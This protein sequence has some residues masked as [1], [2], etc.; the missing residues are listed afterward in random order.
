MR[1]VRRV[2]RSAFDLE[3]GRDGAPRVDARPRTSTRTS[4]ATSLSS[5]RRDRRMPWSRLGAMWS[6]AR[7]D[8][9]A[10]TVVQVA[11]VKW[12]GARRRAVKSGRGPALA[13][14]STSPWPRHCPQP[15]VREERPRGGR[16]R[17]RLIQ[18]RSH[19]RCLQRTGSALLFCRLFLVGVLLSIRQL[20]S[21]WILRRRRGS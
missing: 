3:H 5:L 16:S 18:R 14:L 12:G 17:R 21:A 20:K 8:V 1:A 15:C 9:G 19:S 4:R 10:E 11:V 6:T 7:G 2:A 13:R